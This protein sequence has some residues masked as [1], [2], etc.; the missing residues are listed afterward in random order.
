M[1][2]CFPSG[3]V[4]CRAALPL[5]LLGLLVAAGPVPAQE[6]PRA[7]IERAIQ[8][9]GGQARLARARADR[10]KL[11]GTLLVGGNRVPFVSETTVQLPG[12]FKSVVQLSGG[13]Q[14]HTVVHLLNGQQAR[15]IL[16]GQGQELTSVSREQLRQALSLDQ[17]IRLVPLLSDP[18]FRVALLG[19][20]AVSGRPALGLLVTVGGQRELRLY[21]DKATA[22]L[23]KSE[24][25]QDGPE[26]KKV[27]QEAFYGDFRDVEGVRRP[28]KVIA[29]RDGARI[30]EAELVDVK[31]FE[32]IDPAEFTRP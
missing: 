22:L 24:H 18:S 21:F 3:P 12:Q 17:A 23:V 6:T 7:L 20:T 2:V 16:D 4:S 19:E 31:Y 15:V 13:G 27:R 28:G 14:T 9:H 25:L 5:A 32:R 8:A 10:V 26:G 1:R 30:M 29:F 11:K